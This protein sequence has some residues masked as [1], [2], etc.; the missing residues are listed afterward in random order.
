MS[1][2]IRQTLKY[3]LAV[4]VVGFVVVSLASTLESAYSYATALSRALPAI[5]GAVPNSPLV[6]GVALAG[7]LL[8]GYVGSRRV[9]L[10]GVAVWCVKTADSVLGGDLFSDP[11]VKGI[12]KAD[13]I[14]WK[15]EYWSG[16]EL[17]PLAQ[18]CPQ[19][20]TELEE[21]VLPKDVAYGSDAGFK[22]NRDWKATEAEAWTAVHGAPKSEST[23]QKSALACTLCRF[24]SPAA[25]TDKL[26]R[27]SGRKIFERHIERMKSG[28]SRGDPFAK[29]EEIA[30]ERNRISEGNP[31][32]EAV[33]DAYAATHE[34]SELIPFDDSIGR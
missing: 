16:G 28:S 13:S 30:A 11:V 10:V 32:P 17:R 21:K 5:P 34:S 7:V 1:P 14:A 20:G 33:W 18:C 24:T 9:N 27:E 25:K 3:L 2:T 22:P 6:W 23:A 19:C 12:V 26:D 4:G 29:Y 31:S 15:F 8:V